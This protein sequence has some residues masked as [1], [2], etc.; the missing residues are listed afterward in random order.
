MLLFLFPDHD[1][2]FRYWAGGYTLCIAANNVTVLYICNHFVLFSRYGNSAL[3]TQISLVRLF[4][5]LP[6]FA[7]LL[8]SKFGLSFS[9]NTV[10]ETNLMF[11]SNIHI[12]ET[13]GP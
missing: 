3:F 8:I 4:K 12:A 7:V 9:T 13:F 1:T 10:L 6:I 5:Y 2:L 11:T